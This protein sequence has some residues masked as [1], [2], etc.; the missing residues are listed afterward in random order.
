MDYTLG[1]RRI[2]WIQSKKKKRNN[3]KIERK[4]MKLKIEN[5]W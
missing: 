5:Q 4:L 2:N 1:K 3:F